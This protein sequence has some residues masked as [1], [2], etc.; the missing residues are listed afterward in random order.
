MDKENKDVKYHLQDKDGKPLEVKDVQK[1]DIISITVDEYKTLYRMVVCSDKVEGTVDEIAED[2]IAISGTFYDAEAAVMNSIKVGDSITAYL[3]ARG[4][5]AA[6]KELSSTMLYGYI[7]QIGQQ[8]GFGNT[9]IKM[10]TGKLIAEDTEMNEQNKD[11]KNEIKILVCQ[12][13]KVEILDVADKVSFNGQSVGASSLAN[14]IDSR[15][16]AVK[17]TLGADGKIRSIESAILRGGEPGQKIKYNVRDKVFG[18]ITNIGSFAIDENTKVICLPETVNTD[19]DYMVQVRI[20]NTDSSRR[21]NAQGYEY[22]PVTKKVKLLVVTEAMDSNQASNIDINKAKVGIVKE[23]RQYAD[24]SGETKYKLTIVEE[25]GEKTYETVDIIDKNRVITEL[26][27]GNLI[28]FVKNGQGKIENVRLIYALNKGV[29]T[30]YR[31]QGTDNEQISGY[32][33]SLDFDEID[34]MENILVTKATIDLDGSSEAIGIA[35]R[36]TPPTFIY[37]ESTK[38][39]RPAAL[40]EAIP[41]G[42]DGSG[43]DRL[44]IIMPNDDVKA[45]VIVR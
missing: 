1:E 14:R 16:M 32:L 29:G 10:V 13:E 43:A 5:V 42:S 4:G 28:Y 9:Q 2:G 24:D 7:A 41:V 33:Q 22:D 27:K 19:K 18:G 37:E 25:G 17:Y 23:M 15:G 26:E 38:D 44:F 34:V 39:S 6:T 35:Q 21:F 12:N 8:G 31:Y 30:F 40:R 3:D 20:D 36:N 45:C 11:D